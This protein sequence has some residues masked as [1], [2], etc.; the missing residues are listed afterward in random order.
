MT[1]VE[2]FTHPTCKGCQEAL[3]ALRE[4]DHAGKLSLQVTSLGTPAGRRRAEA[5]GV[6]SV[7]TVRLEDEFRE[8]NDEQ[9]LQALLADLQ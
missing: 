2:L 1:A 8:L 9:D 7:P 6:A 5:L 3:T 4:L